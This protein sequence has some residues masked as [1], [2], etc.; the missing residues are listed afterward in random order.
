VNTGDVVVDMC[1]VVVENLNAE[2]DHVVVVVG[3]AG[4][5]VDAKNYFES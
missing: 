1:V 5:D 3:V 4:D 2:F